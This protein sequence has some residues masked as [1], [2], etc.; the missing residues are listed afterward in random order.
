MG[1]I[2][3]SDDNVTIERKTIVRHPSLSIYRYIETT[4]HGPYRVIRSYY[5]VGNLNRGYLSDDT[6]TTRESAYRQWNAM[7]TVAGLV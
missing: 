7:M 1:T 6:H 3:R 2:V 4:F 5:K